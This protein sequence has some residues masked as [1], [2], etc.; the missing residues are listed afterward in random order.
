[1]KCVLVKRLYSSS[2]NP[3]VI[4]RGNHTHTHKKKHCRQTPEVT[5]RILSESHFLSSGFISTVKAASAYKGA[6]SRGARQ[7]NSA[8][9]REL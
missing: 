7:A 2:D 9:A 3:V 6:R 8:S 5:F 1:M 4:G